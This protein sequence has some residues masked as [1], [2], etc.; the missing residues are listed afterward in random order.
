MWKSAAAIFHLC[1]P[2]ALELW[3]DVFFFPTPVI[4]LAPSAPH[5][6]NYFQQLEALV[7]AEDLCSIPSIHMVAHN[8]SVAVVLGN[9][10]PLSEVHGYQAYMQCIIHR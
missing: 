3:Q 10:M 8:Q 1:L 4:P 9:S 6:L 5:L 2:R 7:L